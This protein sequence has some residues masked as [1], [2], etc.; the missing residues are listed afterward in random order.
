MDFQWVLERQL[1]VPQLSIAAGKWARDPERSTQP[2]AA[3]SSRASL[4]PNYWIMQKIVRSAKS[5]LC[6][7]I[8]HPY[9]ACRDKALG[10]HT[11]LVNPSCSVLMALRLYTQQR[12]PSALL[13]HS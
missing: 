4:F 13:G 6:I 7:I 10:G 1:P 9:G 2:H 5:G 8:P 3:N 12:R 11:T